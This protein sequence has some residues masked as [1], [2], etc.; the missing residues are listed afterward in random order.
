MPTVAELGLSPGKSLVAY[1]DVQEIH[2]GREGVVGDRVCMLV[3]AEQHVNVNYKEGFVAEPGYQLT[4]REDPS[5]TSIIPVLDTLDGSLEL[6]TKNGD[7][8]VV[9]PVEDIAENR[10]PV[11][12]WGWHGE[13]IDQGDEVAELASEV[14][15]RPVR[16]VRVSN[17]RPRYVEGDPALGRVGFADAHPLTVGSTESLALVNE[18]LANHGQDPIPAK[19][20]RVTLLLDDLMLPNRDS[21]PEN[22]FPEDYIETIT[23]ANNG[24]VAVLRRIK[25]CGRCP[26]PDTNHITGERKGRPVLK[27]LAKLGRHGRH[28]DVGRYGDDP[29][30]FWTQGFVIEFPDGLPEGKT[31]P[32]SRGAEVEVEY[33]D[34]TNWIPTKGE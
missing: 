26:V 31:I 29:E 18:K 3:E 17:E 34:Q 1:D 25:A 19:R 23:V 22:I 16:L 15:G 2:L 32:V 33:A 14:V 21:L 20:A 30:A 12:V 28:V 27:A 6:S 4:L 7:S 11:Q 5:L 9:P 24:L 13:A 8:V 10:I